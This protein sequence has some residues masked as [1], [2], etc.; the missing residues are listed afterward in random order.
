MVATMRPK[1][2]SADRCRSARESQL[3]T[4]AAANSRMGHRGSASSSTNCVAAMAPERHEDGT[5]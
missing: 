1:D 4:R 5:M 3:S 2:P